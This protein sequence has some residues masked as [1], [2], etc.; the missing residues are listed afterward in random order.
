MRLH[1]LATAGLC[2]LVCA[3]S[4]TAALAATGKPSAADR[5]FA[6]LQRVVRQ[7]VD[8]HNS[9]G[10]VAG[11]L[12][13]GGRTRI[14]AYGRGAPGQRVNASSV[15]EIGSITKVFTGT[16]LADMAQRGEVALDTPVASLLPAGVT[17]PSRDGRQITLADLAT[18]TSRLDTNPTNLS[19]TNPYPYADY[20]VAQLYDYL[21]HAT[22]TGTVGSDFEYS[23]TGVG[24]LGHAL[25]L[26]AGTSYEQLAMQRLI[27]PLALDT[28]AITLTP[29]MRQRF[30]AGHDVDGLPA[31]PFEIPALPGAGALRSTVGDMLKF[32][33]ANLSGSGNA[34]LDRAMSTARTPRLTIAPDQEVGLNWFTD[35]ELGRPIVWHN[36]ATYG[37]RSF[38]GLD[39]QRGTAIVV[40]S[41]TK[42]SVDDIGFHALDRR[43]PLDRLPKAIRLPSKTLARFTGTFRFPAFDVRIARA[44]RWLVAK[45]TGQPSIRVYPESRTKFFINKDARL[46]FKLGRDGRATQLTLSQEG[47]D[48]VAPRVG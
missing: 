35:R 39:P 44:K 38:L 24:L 42:V 19:T 4:S 47:Q 25:S 36:G 7:R 43:S 1:L 11:V 31:P 45:P 13:P 29:S 41:A 16:L 48:L 3:T 12:E 10:I 5:T 30:V 21:A 33:A 32:A 6:D 37:H 27:G 17:V 15:F 22:L 23:N 14:F 28:T 46:R 26:R 40:L 18:H 20:T 34:M 9:T 2:A 8:T